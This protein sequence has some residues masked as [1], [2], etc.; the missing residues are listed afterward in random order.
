MKR[1]QSATATG[2]FMRILD[3]CTHECDVAIAIT[4]EMHEMQ[5]GAGMSYSQTTTALQKLANQNP[6]NRNQ[7]NANDQAVVSICLS[8]L[9]QPVGVASTRTMWLAYDGLIMASGRQLY[10]RNIYPALFP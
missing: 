7:E 9:A 5:S 10:L 6:C 3:N 1:V 8:L 2:T 4:N